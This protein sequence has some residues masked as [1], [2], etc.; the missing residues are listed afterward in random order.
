MDNSF[1]APRDFM[2]IFNRLES[3]KSGK[4]HTT[5]AEM[6]EQIL[7]IFQKHTE[8]KLFLVFE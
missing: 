3:N 7:Y 6:E 4:E 8:L 5:V 2:Q 1:Q